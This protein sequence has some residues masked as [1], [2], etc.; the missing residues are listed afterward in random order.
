MDI[1][2]W[3]YRSNMRIR[4][5]DGSLV[6]VRVQWMFASDAAKPLKYPHAY[7]SSN[8]YDPQ[9]FDVEGPGEIVETGKVRNRKTQQSTSYNPVPCPDDAAIWNAS[10]FEGQ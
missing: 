10:P 2:R 3:P 4:S 5:A 1:I 9:G 8:Y 7:G 6:T